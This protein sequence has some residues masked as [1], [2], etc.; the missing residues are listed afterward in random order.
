[1]ESRGSPTAAR[2]AAVLGSRN[3]RR[4]LKSVLTVASEAGAYSV[5]FHVVRGGLT[6]FSVYFAGDFA[7]AG[8]GIQGRGCIHIHAPCHRRRVWLRRRLTRRRALP[9]PRLRRPRRLRHAGAVAG[10]AQNSKYDD[11]AH[12]GACSRW[13]QR[14]SDGSAAGGRRSCEAADRTCHRPHA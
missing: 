9:L 5:G 14:Q 8:K 3:S 6:G 2:S 11:K 13:R 12:A 4:Q 10:R 1:M 7:G